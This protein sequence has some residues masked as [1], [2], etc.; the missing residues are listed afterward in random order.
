MT[1][2]IAIFRQLIVNPLNQNLNKCITTATFLEKL[3]CLNRR[4]ST[5]FRQRTPRLLREPFLLP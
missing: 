4:C 2:A 5:G 1:T 3:S